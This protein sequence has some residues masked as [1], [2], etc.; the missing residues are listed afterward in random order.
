M[1]PRPVY[2]D[3]FRTLGVTRDAGPEAIEEAY[4]ALVRAHPPQRDPER[5]KQVRDAYERISSADGRLEALLFSLEPRGASTGLDGGARGVADL[6]V[7][8]LTAIAAR[9]LGLEPDGGGTS[10]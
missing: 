8:V 10:A 4:L 6:L 7:T 2:R 9:E 1:I 3:P 5:F